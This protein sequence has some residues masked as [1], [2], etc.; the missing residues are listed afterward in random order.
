MRKVILSLGISLDGYIARPSGVVDF[1]FIPRD[2]PIAEGHAG[3][4]TLLMGR[5]TL[6]AALRMSKGRFPSMGMEAFVFS[7]SR[8]SGKQDD[9]TFTSESPAAFVAKLRRR[10][11]KDIWLMG[12]G[13]LAL[14]FFKADLVDEIHLSIVPVLLGEGIPLFLRG[15]PQLAFKLIESRSYSKGLVSLKYG[16]DRRKPKAPRASGARA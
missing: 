3:I 16:R 2:Y 7:R 14:E 12:G 5:K 11:G 6:D 9:W 13:E 4:D 15:H 1:L 10:S 8:P